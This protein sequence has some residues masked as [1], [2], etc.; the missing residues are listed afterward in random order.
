MMVCGTLLRRCTFPMMSGIGV[1]TAVP[2]LIADHDDRMGV[3]AG[4]ID[5]LEAAAER[6][7]NT[8]R[9]EVIGGDDAADGGFRACSDVEGAAGDFADEESVALGAASGAESRKSGQEISRRTSF[10]AR[11]SGEG[12]EPLLVG[13]GGVRTEENAFEPAENRSVRADGQ[14]EAENGEDG[15]SWI[16]AG[17]GESR[18]A[19]PEAKIFRGVEAVRL[20]RTVRGPE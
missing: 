11:G 3:A 18:S 1:E 7:A 19:N 8:N 10:A 5:G 12:D 9:V 16:A 2:Q 15:E 6:W 13:D 17:A 14:D 20:R 4:I